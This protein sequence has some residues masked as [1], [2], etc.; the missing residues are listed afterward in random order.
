MHTAQPWQVFAWTAARYGELCIHIDRANLTH[1]GASVLIHIIARSWR[2]R[3]SKVEAADLVANH[4][5]RGEWAP[6]LTMW[7]GDR[8]AERREILHID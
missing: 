2:Q 4:L 3:W 6:L 8:K 5:R 1:E 7:L